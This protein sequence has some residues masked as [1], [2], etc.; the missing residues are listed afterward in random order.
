MLTKELPF[1]LTDTATGNNTSVFEVFSRFSNTGKQLT[2]QRLS[3]VITHVKESIAKHS[4]KKTT[5]Q[6]VKR[7]II[8]KLERHTGWHWSFFNIFGFES[9]ISSYNDNAFNTVFM[10]GMMDEAALE[11]FNKDTTQTEMKTILQ[12]LMEVIK[13]MDFYYSIPIKPGVVTGTIEANSLIASNHSKEFFGDKFHINVAPESS[14]LMF[15]IEGFNSLGN[16]IK[17]KTT[18]VTPG[19]TSKGNVPPGSGTGTNTNT[20]AD[21]KTKLD[22]LF[23]HDEMKTVTSTLLSA[24]DAN[25]DLVAVLEAAIVDLTNEEETIGMPKTFQNR[26]RFILGKMAI[27]I[28]SRNA[29]SLPNLTAALNKTERTPESIQIV[30]TIKRAI[31]NLLRKVC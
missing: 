10:D 4:G 31:D 22:G 3:E 30:T 28:S 9:I 8:G 21:L 6:D 26:F 1:K 23:K 19:P 7:D 20:N 14:M 5:K 11:A 13:D 24:A 12:S 29:V 27:S 15:D 25:S 18:K 17:N 2:S 16:P